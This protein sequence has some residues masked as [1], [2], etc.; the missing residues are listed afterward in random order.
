MEFLAPVG[1]AL[2]SHGIQPEVNLVQ[3][4]LG[5]PSLG[6][7]TGEEEALTLFTVGADFNM[8]KI[9]KV[10]GA[11]LHFEQMFVPTT[12]NQDYGAYVGDDIGG[13][14]P[15][16][17]P[18]IY[19]LTR[20]TWEQDLGSKHLNVEVGKENMGRYVVKTVCNQDFTCQSP[21]TQYSGGAGLDPAPYANWMW[22]ATVNVTPKL[23]VTGAE[24][25][26]SIAFPFAEGWGLHRTNTKGGD[27][28]IA[29]FDALYASPNPHDPHAYSYEALFVRNTATQSDPSTGATVHGA[30]M[31]YLGGKQSFWAGGAR[32]APVPASVN[33]FASTNISFTPEN[34]TGLTAS[35]NWG[36]Q[37]NGPFAKRPFDSYSLKMTWM[38]ET[39]DEYIYQVAKN[40]QKT[41]RDEFGIGPDANFVVNK[42]LII[43][44]YVTRVFNADN[45]MATT[46]VGKM[47]DGWAG[48]VVFVVLLD[49]ATGLVR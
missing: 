48:G 32:K 25:R 13:Q 30:K 23:H 43:C 40:L 9:A 19:H 26:S 22:R 14:P 27:Y 4:L 28:N 7:K 38:R 49:K 8:N 10:P 45:I 34:N 17:I 21:L 18:Y 20:F 36:V 47:Q 44:P 42:S 37:A 39:Q 15:P 24:W 11:T 35:A 2:A 12:S 16:F 31:L 29:G 3:F 6:Q 1:K 33:A 5:N 46:Q 41:G